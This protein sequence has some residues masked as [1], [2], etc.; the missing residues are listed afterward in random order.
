MLVRH[1]I[2][3]ITSTGRASLVESSDSVAWFQLVHL[4]ANI[5]YN[6]CNAIPLIHLRD[7]SFTQIWVLLNLG[8]LARDCDLH[9]NLIGLRCGNRRFNDADLQSSTDGCFFHSDG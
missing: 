1:R 3:C 5:M 9:D 8:V 2:L 4:R 7:F 6:N